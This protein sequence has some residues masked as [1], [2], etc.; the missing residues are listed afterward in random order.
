MLGVGFKR[1][2]E[3]L[4]SLKA[5]LNLSFPPLLPVGCWLLTLS[6][7]LLRTAVNVLDA[8]VSFCLLNVCDVCCLLEKASYRSASSISKM[9][10]AIRQFKGSRFD[11]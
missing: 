4:T 2:M 7:L 8:K 11:N 1:T 9:T 6:K 3:S 5:K 10:T